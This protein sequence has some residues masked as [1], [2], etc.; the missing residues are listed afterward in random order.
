M[1]R[2]LQALI[3]L[4]T[5][6]ACTGPDQQGAHGAAHLTPETSS[7][8]AAMEDFHRSRWVGT[9]RQNSCGLSWAIDLLQ[10]ENRITGR[11]L[12]EDIQYD[13]YGIIGPNGAMH[14]ARAGKSPSFGGARGPRFIRVSLDFGKWRATG[15]YAVETSTADDCATAVELKRYAP[16]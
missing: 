6:G 8:R 2:A 10:E 1:P 9:G 16:D 13:I 11:L 3:V 4:I 12:L 15:T 7:P 5:L 14:G